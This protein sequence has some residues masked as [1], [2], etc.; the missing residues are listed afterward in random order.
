M[1]SPNNADVVGAELF[2]K[3][4]QVAIDKRADGIPTRGQFITESHGA[5]KAGQDGRSPIEQRVAFD[6]RPDVGI[7]TVT[8]GPPYGRTRE[9]IP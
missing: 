5:E 2:P 4:G 1:G 9:R 7:P 6:A 3:N 8:R